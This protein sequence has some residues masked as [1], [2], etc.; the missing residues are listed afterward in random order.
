MASLLLE[1]PFGRSS[2]QV[3]SVRKFGSNN[4]SVQKSLTR[5]SSREKFHLAPILFF[6]KR[7]NKKMTP[8][9]LGRWASGFLDF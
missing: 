7:K 5:I 3:S 2:N 8:T 9:V 6:G 4:P 1:H